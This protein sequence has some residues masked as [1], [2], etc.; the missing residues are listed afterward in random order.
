MALVATGALPMAL[1][2]PSA[3]DHKT[4]PRQVQVHDKATSHVHLRTIR[5]GEGTVRQNFGTWERDTTYEGLEDN[6]FAYGVPLY[7]RFWGLH[8]DKR[9]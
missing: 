5:R 1:P 9:K 4:P 3:A 7:E 6:G 8:R 2:A